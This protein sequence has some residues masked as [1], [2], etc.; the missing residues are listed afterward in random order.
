VNDFIVNCQFSYYMRSA[1]FWD[2]TQHVVI[3]PYHTH[4]YILQLCVITSY[5]C[6]CS[7]TMAINVLETCSYR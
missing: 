5:F 2:I 1:L 4:C 3:I 7:L 6:L